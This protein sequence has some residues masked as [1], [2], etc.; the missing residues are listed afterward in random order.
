MT[1]I[2]IVEYKPCNYCKILLCKKSVRIRSFSGLYFPVFGLNTERYG[3]CLRIQSKCGKIRTTKTPNKDTFHAVL[4]LRVLLKTI[5]FYFIIHI[6]SCHHSLLIWLDVPIFRL[7][8]LKS[9]VCYKK[10]QPPEVFYKKGV[11]KNFAKFTGKYLSQSLFLNKVAGLRP[12]TLL[13]K[14]L[15]HRCFPVNFAK[16]LRAPFLQNTYGRL[17]LYKVKLRRWL[18]GEFIPGWNF[19]SVYR[20]EKNCNYMKNF[21]PSWKYFNPGWNIIASSKKKI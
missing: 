11:L 14:R 15:W 6:Y 13:K 10:K 2:C 1:I 3:V 17:L 21:N 5:C 18:Y 20:V 12:A 16:F 9:V 4:P 7:W 8:L 19:N